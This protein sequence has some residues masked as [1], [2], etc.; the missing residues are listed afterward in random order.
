M[1]SEQLH[2]FCYI[3]KKWAE[4]NWPLPNAL[5]IC[6]LNPF[7]SPD[8][9]RLTAIRRQLK[10]PSNDFAEGAS[11]GF[12]GRLCSI[13]KRAID[14]CLTQGASA[15]LEMPQ[16]SAMVQSSLETVFCHNLAFSPTGLMREAYLSYLD[17]IYIRNEKCPEHREDVSTLKVEEISN[18]LRAW[19][20][21]EGC[22]FV[23][24]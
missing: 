16:W 24:D 13:A 21:M 14:S 23:G 12:G 6:A 17:S 9:E 2:G 1:E 7:L 20:F 8:S 15:D 5:V 10:K 11:L 4:H 19:T 18:W 3:R 22:G